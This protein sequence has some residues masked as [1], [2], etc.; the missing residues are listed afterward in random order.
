M[1]RLPG[2][3]PSR[4]LEH[5]EWCEVLGGLKK[6]YCDHRVVPRELTYVTTVDVLFFSIFPLIHLEFFKLSLT[7]FCFCGSET[8]LINI[9][10]S[11]WLSGSDYR[12]TSGGRGREGTSYSTVPIFLDCDKRRVNSASEEGAPRFTQPY[13]LASNRLPQSRVTERTIGATAAPCPPT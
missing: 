10:L 11:T 2:L 4:R 5:F 6:V 7:T 9:P 12:D 8:N 13:A 3:L 1:I